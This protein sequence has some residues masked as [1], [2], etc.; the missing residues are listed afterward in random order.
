MQIFYLK[1]STCQAAGVVLYFPRFINLQ[2]ATFNLQLATFNPDPM[3]LIPPEH[4][5]AILLRLPHPH[6]L[7]TAEWARVKARYGWQPSFALWGAASDPRAA[8]LILERTLTLRGFALPLRVIYV[9]KGPNLPWEDADLF[10]RVL[11]DLQDFARRRGAIFLKLDPDVPLGWGEPG[12]PK[13]RE[14]ALGTAVTAALQSRGWCYSREQIQFRNTV[15]LDIAPPEDEILARMKQKTRYNIR[16]AGRRGVSVREGAADDWPLLYRMYAE[17]AARDGFTI[18]P[19][20]Y[21]RTVWE[22]FAP[23]REKAPHAHN[24]I[25]EVE[26]EPVAALSLFCFGERAYY[27][28]GMSR[29][30][31]RNKMPTYLLQWEAIRLAKAHGCTTY[32]L[33]GAPET[34]DESDSMWGVYR[35]KRGWGG[36]VV[37]TLGAWDYPARPF[38]YRLYGEVL[39]RV[40]G[41]LRRNTNR[42]E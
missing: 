7:Q 35:F 25:A 4:W 17:T 33:W 6:F 11:G 38:W 5:N 3:Q 1:S 20:G 30:R 41:L 15:L 28:Y 22:I 37:R 2:P 21:Y 16:L 14:A 31:H 18:R 19:E 34:F 42:D 8:A 26:G 13:A 39:P 24:L 29:P 27:V 40:L 10:A 32:D 9:P 12:T 36:E 23:V